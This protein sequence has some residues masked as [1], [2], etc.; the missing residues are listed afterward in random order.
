M[1]G[2]PTDL[3]PE[4]AAVCMDAARE[5]MAPGFRGEGKPFGEEQPYP[6]GAS[7]TDTL[8]AFLGRAVP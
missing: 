5:R 3:D 6:P 4:L 2:Q 8:A 1:T 7:G